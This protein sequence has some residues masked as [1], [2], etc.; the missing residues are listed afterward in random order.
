MVSQPRGSCFAVCC[1]LPAGPAIEYGC[2]F[3]LYIF[4]FVFLKTT[5]FWLL[6]HT[7]RRLLGARGKTEKI[8]CLTV[9]LVMLICICRANSTENWHDPM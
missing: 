4:S 3:E 8:Y 5:F 1:V 2:K 7:R 9:V 6:V